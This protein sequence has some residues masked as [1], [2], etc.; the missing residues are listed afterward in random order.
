[1]A[2][3]LDSAAPRKDPHPSSASNKRWVSHP[4]PTVTSPGVWPPPSIPSAPTRPDP[5][6]PP[7]RAPAGAS[8]LPRPPSAVN[9]PHGGQSNIF[10]N[11]NHLTSSPHLKPF[12]ELPTA[13]G[14]GSSF[15]SAPSINSGLSPPLQ[16]HPSP[17]APP[18][19]LSPHLTPPPLD[20]GDDLITSLRGRLWGWSKRSGGEVPNSP[21][22]WQDPGR[23]MNP[24]EVRL[25]GAIYFNPLQSV[26]WWW[27][28]VMNKLLIPGRA[29]VSSP[30]AA[31]IDI[32]V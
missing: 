25:S 16:P 31:F 20:R 28:R 8:K 23:A 1:M 13:L 4:T 21:S 26:F 30:T 15:L 19:T 2:L 29:W 18:H 24:E 7:P 10:K 9:S 32:R 5:P 11:I 3:G 17:P 12:P 6:S 27:G 14:M 22:E